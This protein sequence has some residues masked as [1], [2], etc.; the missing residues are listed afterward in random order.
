MLNFNFSFITHKKVRY[1]LLSFNLDIHFV[2]FELP[3]WCWFWTKPLKCCIK[4]AAKIL[5]KTSPKNIFKWKKYRLPVR[6]HARYLSRSISKAHVVYVCAFA[7]STFKSPPSQGLD[8]SSSGRYRTAPAHCREDWQ[9][10]WSVEKLC[11]QAC[12][13]ALRWSILMSQ[14]SQ[15][16]FSYFFDS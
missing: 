16:V 6:I 8:W 4:E 15:D 13:K 3:L 9:R 11:T 5:P 2:C 14:V 12:G 7:K 1:L 10:P